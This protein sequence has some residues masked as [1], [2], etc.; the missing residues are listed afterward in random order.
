[1]HD[2]FTYFSFQVLE[3]LDVINVYTTKHY[4][5]F[6]FHTLTD[7]QLELQRVKLEE[8]LDHKFDAFV[9]PR[10]NHTDKIAIINEKNKDENPGE[11]DGVLTN[12]SNVALGTISADCQN[13]YLYDQVE[14]VIGCVHSGWRGTYQKIAT[15]A[16]KKMIKTYGSDPADIIVCIGPS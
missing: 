11:V 5:N 6:D 1:M 13:L 10:Q 3:S 12:L 16:I 15:K 7:E 2:N 14:G 8:A 9:L 4:F